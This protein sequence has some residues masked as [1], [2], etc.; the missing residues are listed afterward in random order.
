MK[1]RI[2]SLL[3]LGAAGLLGATAQGNDLE[4]IGDR[5]LIPLTMQGSGNQLAYRYD[6]PGILNGFVKAGV[7]ARGF[8]APDC[9]IVHQDS[10]PMDTIKMRSFLNQIEVRNGRDILW[11]NP[12][13]AP[14]L[15]AK[16]VKGTFVYP[17]SDLSAFVTGVDIRTVDRSKNFL[18]VAVESVG[19]P[20]P[21]IGMTLSRGCNLVLP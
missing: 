2:I 17:I 18:Q 1:N 9:L 20:A 14:V 4:P 11:G 7:L 19:D 3:V 21:S 10:R 5:V 15:H 12:V 8:D 16:L 6:Y 13:D